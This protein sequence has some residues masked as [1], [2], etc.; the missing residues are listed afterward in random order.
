M[1]ELKELLALEATYKIDEELLDLFL[2]ESK[3]INLPPRAAII[4]SGEYNPNVYI[5]KKGLIRGFYQ[6][7]K[8]EKTVGF[9]LP[10]TILISYHCYYSHQ[11]SYHR[12]ETLTPSVLLV[13]KK[14]HFDKLINESHQFALWNLSMLQNQLYYNEYR[15]T[16]LTGDAKERL[17]QLLK[18]ISLDNSIGN[19]RIFD[20]NV[21]KDDQEVLK[22]VHQR[23]KKIYK[24]VPSKVLASYLGIT[25]VHL[26]R[27]K[28]ELF[29]EQ[30]L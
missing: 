2:S 26:S 19:E 5:I 16:I 22:E 17:R 28:K 30:E 29:T 10:G 15:D 9:A 25:E 14:S 27:I 21:K 6:D 8:N 18:R 11:P 1:K 20:N 4:D 12:L 23:W 24:I 7:N 13:I 3:E